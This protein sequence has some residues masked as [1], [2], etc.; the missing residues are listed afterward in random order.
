MHWRMS[1]DHTMKAAARQSR[2]VLVSYW[3]PF[4]KDCSRMDRTVFRSDD[5]LEQMKNML[6]VRMDATFQK[7]RGAELGFREAPSFM[8][9]SPYGEILRRGNGPMDIDQFLAF[10]VMAKLNQ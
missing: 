1:L 3:Q 5:V 9:I 6:S 2:L 7:K 4:N 10:L 8:V